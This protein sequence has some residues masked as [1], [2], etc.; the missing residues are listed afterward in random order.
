VRDGPACQ[1][2]PQSDSSKRGHF[3]ATTDWQSDREDEDQ[4][5][6]TKNSTSEHR[7]K[8]TVRTL[9]TYKLFR[10]KNQDGKST[11]VSVDP[12]L[13]TAAIKALGDAARV[14]QVVRDASRKYD[15]ANAGC[16]RSR[17]VQRELLAAHTR[18]L[19]SNQAISAAVL[20][21]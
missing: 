6:N 8:Q 9:Y 10:V 20:A 15:T 4:M 18:A 12:A 19:T 21:A 11:T 5:E 16:S 7:T 3:R 2:K 1:I 14:G 17:F 13:V